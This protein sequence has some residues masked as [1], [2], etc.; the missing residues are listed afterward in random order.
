MKN[1]IFGFALLFLFS[2]DNDDQNT[3][4]KELTG[5]WNWVVSS[6]GIAGLTITPETEKKTF[7]LE[8]SA[9]HVKKYQDGVLL[10]DE[11]YSIQT[12]KSILGD[13]REMIVT[14]NSPI[15]SFQIEGNDLY[16]SQECYDCFQSK[17]TRAPEKFSF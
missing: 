8:F 12:N 3:S 1:I 10:Y 16:L 14:K 17:Y 5:K 11:P 13:Y 4:G 15:Q 6:G 7:V 9:T 2:C